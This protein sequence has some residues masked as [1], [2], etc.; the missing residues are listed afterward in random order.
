MKTYLIGSREALAEWFSNITLMGEDFYPITLQVFKGDKKHRS[1]QQNDLSH[2]WYRSI[3]KQSQHM[4]MDEVKRECKLTCGVPI[5]RAES[6]YFKRMW[7]TFIKGH[8]YEAR[9]EMMDLLP[10]TSLMTPSQM[11]DYLEAVYYKYNQAGYHLEWPD[12]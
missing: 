9:I 10:V 5:L 6:E 8:D 7:S 3:A 12:E 2:V 11:A 1:L 4:S